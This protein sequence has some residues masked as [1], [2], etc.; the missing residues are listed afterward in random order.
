MK[1][2]GFLII[3]INFLILTHIFSLD[4][5][6][7]IE[8]LNQ[9]N[10]LFQQAVN[11]ETSNPGEAQSLYEESLI[12]Y[13]QIAEDIQNGKL[14]Y[15]IGNIYFHLDDIGRAIL[16]YKKAALLMPG[17]SNLK[18]NLEAARALRVDTLNEKES[19]RILK[20]IFFIHYKLSTTVRALLF[21]AF[22]TFAWI[23]AV[24]LLF[25]K[26]IPSSLFQVFTSTTLVFAFLA[27]VFLGSIMIDT[28]KIQTHPEGVITADAVIARKGDGLSYSPSF[29]DPLHS[30]LEFT[31]LDERTGWY[32]IEISDNTRTWI[33][34][35]AASL[36]VLN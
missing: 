20:T 2:S 17:D 12:R 25:K 9:G 8:L 19:I 31:L 35:N 29:E 26:K 7:N 36:I 30:G 6:L 23:S 4:S 27:L 10:D 18:E 11:I 1:K 21:V 3:I 13:L 15:N 22:I 14:F 33:P 24:F 34:A 5:K 16:F 28:I 32:Y